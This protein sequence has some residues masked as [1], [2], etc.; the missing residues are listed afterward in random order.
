[1]ETPS[2][3]N[4][5]TTLEEAKMA[6]RRE[7]SIQPLHQKPDSPFVTHTDGTLGQLHVQP[8]QLQRGLDDRDPACLLPL[9]RNVKVLVASLT[10]TNKRVGAIG[11]QM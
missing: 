4:G 7:P 6:V 10:L 5:R 3:L 1:M 11:G 9:D 2:W 8:L